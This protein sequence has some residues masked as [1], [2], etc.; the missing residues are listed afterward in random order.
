MSARR[1]SSPVARH[2]H[3]PIDDDDPYGRLVHPGD[4]ALGEDGQP[5]IDTVM[6]RAADDPAPHAAVVTAEP[7][8]AASVLDFYR[9]VGLATDRVV[10]RY[11]VAIAVEIALIVAYVALR[12]GAANETAL[13]AWFIAASV[14][15]LASPTSG[16]VVLAAVAPFNEGVSLTRDVGS[17]TVLAGLLLAGVLVRVVAAR[18]NRISAPRSVMASIALAIGLLAISAASLI[19]TLQRWGRDFAEPAAQVWLQGIGTMLVVFLA[20]AWVGRRGELR[21][22]LIAVAATSAAG[23]ISLADFVSDS[24]MRAG[25]LGWATAGAFIPERLTGVI[26]SPTSTAALVMLPVCV[27]VAAAMLGRDVRLRIGSVAL[28]IPLL[29]AAYLTY[30][31]AVFLA[32]FLLV[33]VVGWRIRRSIG[34]GILVVGIVLGGLALPAYLTLRGSAVGAA[35][36]P[37]PGQVLIASDQQRLTAWATAGRMF[38]D[39]PLTG[40]GYRAYRQLSVAFGDPTLNAPH[41]EWLRFFA[42]GGLVNGLVGLAFA[43]VTG[44]VLLRRRGWLETGLF[45]AFASLCLAAA[46][47]NP[48]LF[49]QVTIPG[50]LLAGVGVGLA[51]RPLLATNE[52]AEQPPEAIGAEAP[53]PVTSSA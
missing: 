47:N 51:A 36:Q 50:F 31:R 19:Q 21:P 17:K 4:T 35:S 10:R 1:A 9:A 53:E 15:A 39:Q 2:G 16:L 33:L 44:I 40:Q 8:G 13:T 34:I 6:D 38:L 14:L 37:L 26:R 22:V 20:A 28:A 12:A 30:N 23:L 49:N 25:P 3:R 48:F 11:R 52:V 45:G 42:E 27:L 5:I 41:N 18:P 7:S 24:T 29:A 43:V 32:L 46:F